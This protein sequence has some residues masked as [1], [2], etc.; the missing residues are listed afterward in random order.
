MSN[1][2]ILGNGFDI[3]HNMETRFNQFREYLNA[4]YPFIPHKALYVPET[5][6]GHHGEEIQDSTEVVGLIAYLL[7]EAAI[8]IGT[9]NDWS[10]IEDLLGK[11]NLPEC[12][13]NVE[14]QYDKDGDRNYFL[15]YENA[16]SICRNM[17]LAIPYITD[18]LSEWIHTVKISASPLKYFSEIIHPKKDFFLTFNYTQTLEKLYGCVKENVCHIHGMASD[19]PFLQVDKLVLGHCGQADYLNEERVPYEMGDGIQAIYENLRKN[20]SEQIML[21]ENF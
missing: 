3:A 7:D 9:E 20:T 18:L 4:N 19:D 14:P 10:K 11:L 5:I 16:E 17:A 15:E 6:T 13:D 1:L 8:D 2:F 12:F 21:H